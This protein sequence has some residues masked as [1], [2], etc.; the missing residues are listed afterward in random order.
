MGKLHLIL[1]A[2]LIIY[3][4]NN[5][6]NSQTQSIDIAT[7]ND[8]Y[9]IHILYFKANVKGRPTYSFSYTELYCIS[10]LRL[11]IIELLISN[12]Q[13]SNIHL[14]RHTMFCNILH[15]NFLCITTSYICNTCQTLLTTS[16]DT[17]KS[18]L[19]HNVNGFMFNVIN[20]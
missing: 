8:N 4:H 12:V 20:K 10:I 16:V 5:H 3:Q 17:R 11:E 7:N 1:T 2:M 6:L 19:H 9:I 18:M 15:Q 14:F 13:Y